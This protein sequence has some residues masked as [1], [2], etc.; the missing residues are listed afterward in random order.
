MRS[1]IHR[2]CGIRVADVAL[3]SYSGLVRCNCVKT[4]RQLDMLEFYRIF[5]LNIITIIDIFE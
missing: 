4:V 5:V 2:I 1:Q 3:C